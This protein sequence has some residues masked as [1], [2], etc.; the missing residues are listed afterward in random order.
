[1]WQCLDWPLSMCT[2]ACW[3]CLS[4]WVIFKG[5]IMNRK[6]LWGHK[7]PSSIHPVPDKGAVS[8]PP[9]V[10]QNP[11]WPWYFSPLQARTLSPGGGLDGHAASLS[12]SITIKSQKWYS[13]GIKSFHA[14]TITLSCLGW[15]NIIF[16]I[17][18]PIAYRHRVK[19]STTS[20]NRSEVKL[21]SFTL[22]QK[23]YLGIFKLSFLR[24]LIKDD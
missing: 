6:R 8:T 13:T 23:D 3:T 9:E 7:Q 5:C 10:M 18:S 2:A 12:G 14:S 21:Y 11:S 24:M 19:I 16:S 4:F 17:Q 20:S 15:M 22:P 1:M